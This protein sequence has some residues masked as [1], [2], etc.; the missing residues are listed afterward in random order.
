MIIIGLIALLAAVIVGV[1]GVL[2]NSGG[3]HALTDG[4][5]VFGY[6]VTGSTGTLFLSGIVIGAIGMCGLS[7]LLAGTLRGHRARRELHD[8][9]RE[10]AGGNIGRANQEPVHE[11]VAADQPPHGVDR[12][13]R[14]TGGR[15]WRHP[16]GHRSESAATTRV[17]Q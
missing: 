3:T 15:D 8:S 5:A 11:S 4:F 10:P 2:N 6:H 12:R 7:L 13:H 1:A 16:F 14:S 17:A 9:R